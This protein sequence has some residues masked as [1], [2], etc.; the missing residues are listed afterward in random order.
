MVGIALSKTRECKE[1]KKIKQIDEFKK[2]DENSKSKHT[3][4]CKEC[5]KNKANKTRELK[6]NKKYY[7]YRFINKKC[8]TLYVGKTTNIYQRI[9][10]HKQNPE[11]IHMLSNTYYIQYSEMDSDYHMNMYEVH[12]ICKD[13]PKYNKEFA[14]DNDI[15]LDIPDLKWKNFIFIQ[16]T[17]NITRNYLVRFGVYLSR[18][19]VIDKIKNDKTG[20]FKDVFKN[21]FVKSHLTNEYLTERGMYVGKGVS[22]IVHYYDEETYDEREL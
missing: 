17:N 6:S 2:D 12:Y 11:A 1:C 3:Q 21:I 8:E 14:S 9:R 16:F 7:V 5:V 20:L 4:V 13:H 15:L 19:E 22:D 10:Q 18:D